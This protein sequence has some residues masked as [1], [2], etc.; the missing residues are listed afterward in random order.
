LDCG[1]CSDELCEGNE[2]RTCTALSCEELGWECGGGSDG[3]NGTVE[4]GDCAEANGGNARC[5]EHVCCS[6]ADC[7]A[8][9]CGDVPDGC[10]GS[11]DCGPCQAELSGKVCGHVSVMV[12][13]GP[14][15]DGQPACSCEL[16]AVCDPRN[17]ACCVPLLC[18]DL[19]KTG[20]YDGSDG[21]G[22]VLRCEA[23]PPPKK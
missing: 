6:P 3:C 16:P 19:C 14:R 21:C 20:A 12:C 7:P 17:G 5:R 4:C 2:C 1:A 22:G 11:L 9:A 23:C 13:L 10:G 8:D 18:A 15:A